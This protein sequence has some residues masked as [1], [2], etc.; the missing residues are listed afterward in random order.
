MQ[1]AQ[2]EAELRAAWALEVRELAPLDVTLNS[3]V[4]TAR[5]DPDPMLVK[6]VSD[7]DPFVAGLEVAEHLAGDLRSG[8][9]LRTRSGELAVE[10]D[11]GWLALLYREPGR[12]LQLANE[13]DRR[14]WGA[15]LGD[16]HR[17][18]VGVTVTEPL[19]VWPWDWLDVDADHLRGDPALRDAIARAREAAERYVDHHGP[20]TGLIHGDPS[21]QE[22]LLDRTGDVAVVDWG[23]VQHGPLLYDVASARRFAGSASAFRIVLDAYE[24]STDTAV[25]AAGLHVFHRYREAVQAWYFS[26]R[27]ARGDTT[28]GDG[29]FNRAGL[30]D[31]RTALASLDP[32]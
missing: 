17:R 30:H 15:R 11:H 24:R 18:L 21:P 23:A 10:T 25:P 12:P 32:S 29:A 6:L 3:R 16:L 2:I 7:R 8:P 19:P 22:F 20:A 4:W 1:P 28:G 13:S 26:H 5:T 14:L 27:I 9:P 31:A